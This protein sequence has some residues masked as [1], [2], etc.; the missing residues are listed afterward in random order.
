[1]SIPLKLFLVLGGNGSPFLQTSA[2]YLSPGDQGI[3]K[4]RSAWEY[5]SS[6][7]APKEPE[8]LWNKNAGC[9]KKYHSLLPENLNQRKQSIYFHL[10]NNMQRSIVYILFNIVT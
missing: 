5:I 7:E 10:Y 6:V 3:L 1:M 8:P 9:M 2:R 4:G